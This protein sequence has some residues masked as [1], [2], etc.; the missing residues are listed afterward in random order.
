MEQMTSWSFDAC[1]ASDGQEG[2]A[3]LRAAAGLGVPV[4]CVVLDYHMPEMNGEEVARAIRDDADIAGTPIVLLTSV[5]LTMTSSQYAAL[6]VDSYLVKP[7]RSSA[8]LE[9]ITACIQKSRGT[10]QATIV[11]TASSQAD[12]IIGGSAEI[13]A[14]EEASDFSSTDTENTSAHRLDIL[15]AEDNEVNQLVFTQILSEMPYTFEVVVN[16]ELAVEAW[17]DMRPRLVLM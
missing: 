1:A 5:D 12:E 2:L 15:L 3:I 8:L 17:H 4:D 16:G 13:A 7:A 6:G 9:V 11:S 14:P 10:S